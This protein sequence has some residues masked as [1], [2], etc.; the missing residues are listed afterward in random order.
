MLIL[1]KLSFW[2]ALVG[3][4]AAGLLI[5]RLRASLVEPVPPPPVT[6]APK[7]YAHS[8][9]A[10][11]IVEALR[12]NTLIGTPSPGLVTAVH[13]K[14]WDKVEAGAP[15][16][17]LD[18]RDLQ[19]ALGPQRAQIA[20]SE[21]NLQRL[22]DQLARLE[23]VSDP[24]AISTEDL[25]LRRSDILV[26]QAQLD[27]ARATLAQTQSLIERLVVRAPIAGTVLQLNTRAGEYLGLS[28]QTP[29]LVLGAI[30]QLQVRAEVD[31]Q[32]APRVRP[33]AR[34]SAC[35]KG[36]SSHPI[37][38]E[39]VRIEPYIVPKRSLTGASIERVD[40]R[41]LQV[42]FR[43]ANPGDNRVYVGQQMDIY[44]EEKP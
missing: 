18:S 43:F 23:A 24:R 7:P 8:L 5:V 42:I 40:T 35:V 29:P 28:S 25:K 16:F 10:A 15:L 9:G 19:A 31:E 20:V 41:V 37:P 32:I 30:D 12:E 4:I 36:D 6:P 44:I 3:V 26:A 22:R 14:V 2:L 34:A 27:A 11:G 21:A 1:R 39:F 38:L 33:G 13:V 17:T